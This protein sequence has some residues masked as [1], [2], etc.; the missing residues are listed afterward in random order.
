ML[1]CHYISDPAQT[2]LPT[3]TDS[4]R[5]FTRDIRLN[6]RGGKIDAH[7]VYNATSL[8]ARLQL[9]AAVSNSYK[10]LR[11]CRLARARKLSF[12]ECSHRGEDEKGRYGA[13]NAPRKEIARPRQV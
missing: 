5:V 12:W 2:V 9:L 11:R 13:H 1:T 7:P 4:S 8:L 6:P 10:Y 3:L